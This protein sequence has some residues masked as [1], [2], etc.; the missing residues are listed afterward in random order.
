MNIRPKLVA[1]MHVA[2][3][4][5]IQLIAVFYGPSYLMV[6]VKRKVVSRIKICPKVGNCQ[7]AR[8]HNLDNSAPKRIIIL[9]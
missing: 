1:S 3:E 9:R 2:E 7:A 4:K 8:S 5:L 6:C